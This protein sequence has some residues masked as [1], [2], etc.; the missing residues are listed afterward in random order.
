MNRDKLEERNGSSDILQDV[1]QRTVGKDENLRLTSTNQLKLIAMKKILKIPVREGIDQACHLSM[2][3][4]VHSP[5]LLP[6]LKM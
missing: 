6:V 1:S 2:S 4:V 3:L 5:G